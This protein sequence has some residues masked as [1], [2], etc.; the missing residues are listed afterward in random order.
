MEFENEKKSSFRGSWAHGIGSK[1]F[2]EGGK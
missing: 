2:W 1:C